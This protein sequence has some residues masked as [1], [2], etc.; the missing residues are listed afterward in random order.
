MGSDDSRK[1]ERVL[2]TGGSGFIASHVLN[3]LLNDGRFEVVVTAR[4]QE[5]GKRIQ[6]SVKPHHISYVVVEDIAKEG[7]FDNVFESQPF[8]YVVHTASPYHID[9]QDPV[10]D[11]L[12]PAING[13][14][15]LL[16]AVYIHAPTVKRVVITSSSA[17]I[18]DPDFRTEVYDESCWA[19]TTYEDAIR[20]PARNAYRAS[21][22]LSEKSAWEFM[23]TT[24]RKTFD[25]AVINCTYTFGP[26][27]QK[28]PS[29]SAMNTSNH[30]VRDMLMGKMKDGLEPTAPVFTWVDVRDVA[31]AHLKAMTL[32]E[33]GGNRFYIVGGHFSNKQIADVIRE[34]F[35]QFANR[36][37]A[38]AVD[39]VPSDVY[40]FNNSKSKKVLGLN[41]TLFEKSIIDTVE[42]MLDRFPELT[43]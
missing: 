16:T 30:R 38:D 22:R 40:R 43:P 33:A 19:L 17:A 6:E 42:S 14:T 13:T 1:V 5:K 8:D 9:V 37:P 4:S 12:E 18:I 10:K 21:K 23:D 26:V 25:L 20:D 35:P 2:L 11:F 27:Q 29:L 31:M 3:A 36:L 32:P 24:V 15:G 28:L 7:A 39:D 34:R 41:Y